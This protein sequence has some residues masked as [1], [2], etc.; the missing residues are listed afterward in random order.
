MPR[1][2]SKLSQTDVAR[3]LRAVRETG[4]G[5]VEVHPDGRMIVRPPTSDDTARL[6]L[7]GSPDVVL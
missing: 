3:V 2:V 5:V 7:V 6:D 1:R 4:G